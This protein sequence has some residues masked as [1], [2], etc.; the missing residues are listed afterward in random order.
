MTSRSCAS[1]NNGNHDARLLYIMEL[2]SRRVHGKNHAKRVGAVDA[3]RDFVSQDVIRNAAAI[4][5][6]AISRSMKEMK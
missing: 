3:R 2:A 5:I 6:F 1:A 4:N